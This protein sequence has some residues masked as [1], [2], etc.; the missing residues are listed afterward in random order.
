MD[1]QKA[2][3]LAM[4]SDFATAE[5]DANS[6][7][8]LRWINAEITYYWAYHLLA[9]GQ[10]YAARFNVQPA[11]FDF[12]YDAPIVSDQVSCTWYQQ[13]ILA[14]MARQQLKTGSTDNFWAG[15]YYL[16]EK[17]LSGKSLAFFR[18]ELIANA[19]SFERFTEVL[20]LYT[21][22]LQKTLSVCLMTR[23]KVCIKNMPG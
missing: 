14:F 19:F 9:Y 2:T 7:A 16:A 15:Q 11:F 13:F 18:S 12:L 23:W 22:F 4:L 5:P 20:P 10:V 21:H 1:A 8:F 17:M 6:A 3:S